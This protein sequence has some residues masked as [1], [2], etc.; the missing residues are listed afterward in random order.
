MAIEALPLVAQYG[1]AATFIGTLLE[2]ET[3]LILSGV[4]AARAVLALPILIGLGAVA[5]FMTDNLFFGFGRA[6]GPAL[7]VHL[8]RC[9]VSAHRASGLVA[10]LPNTAVIGLRFFYGM[11]SVGPAIIG[12][13]NMS[14]G[15][16][17]ALDALA[18]AL[19]SSCW[20]SAGFLLGETAQV[21]LERFGQFGRMLFIGLLAAAAIGV[22]ALHLRRRRARAGANVEVPTSTA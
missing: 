15:R 3:V 10:R 9:A 19:W 20:T 4:A 13:G 16:F 21:L 17:A 6:L 12:S 18:A 1:Y 5:A 8:P 22:L 2:G 14:W 11:R 7:F